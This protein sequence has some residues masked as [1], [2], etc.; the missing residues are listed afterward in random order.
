MLQCQLDNSN[1]YPRLVLA[2]RDMRKANG[3]DPDTGMGGGNE[4]WVGLSIAM[5]VLDSLTSSSDPVGARW[6]RLLTHHRISKDDSD[7][8]Y[9]LR[10]SILHGYG[11]P[12]PSSTGNRKVLL[13]PYQ[14]AYAVDTSTAGEALVSVPVFCTRL[15]ERIA[16]AAPGDWDTSLINTNVQM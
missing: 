16:A 13:T 10:N 6:E 4:S 11:L 12:L 2:L 5:I 3:R 15:V 14:D 9:A 8:I 1:L 7:I